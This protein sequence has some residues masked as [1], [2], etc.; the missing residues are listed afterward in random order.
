[1]SEL[2]TLYEGEAIYLR[3]NYSSKQGASTITLQVGE[4]PSAL[5]AFEGHEG[6]RYMIALVEI[7]NDEQPTATPSYKPKK[8]QTFS[9][10]LALR[11]QE[12]VFWDFLRCE[13]SISVYSEDEAV[14]AVYA[15]LNIESRSVIDKDNEAANR[16][17]ERILQPYQK[18]NDRGVQV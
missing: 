15:I 1:M 9:Q 7:G 11:C 3:S 12:E 4:S 10:W 13:H 16:F 2:K 17:R 18:W 6:K 8:P 14:R 5:E